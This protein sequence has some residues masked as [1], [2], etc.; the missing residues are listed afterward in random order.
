MKLVNLI[1]VCGGK[2]GCNMHFEFSEGA[3]AEQAAKALREHRAE[4]GHMDQVLAE[5]NMRRTLDGLVP[6]TME[7][8]L[9]QPPKKKDE[10]ETQGRS[11]DI[12]LDLGRQNRESLRDFRTNVGRMKTEAEAAMERIR[13]ENEERR[14]E[15][16]E[17]ARAPRRRHIAWG[18]NDE[19]I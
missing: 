1:I 11:D 19:N 17:A 4:P 13:Y 18:P 2:L 15:A 14:Q 16:R 7:E 5:T 8:L 12:L 6:L 3:T 10:P 9:G